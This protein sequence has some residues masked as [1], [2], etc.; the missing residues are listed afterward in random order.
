MKIDVCNINGTSDD[1]LR[2][3]VY[4]YSLGDKTITFQDISTRYNS[5]YI[6]APIV[7]IE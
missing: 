7:V 5:N 3:F 1:W 6:P 2:Y 4:T